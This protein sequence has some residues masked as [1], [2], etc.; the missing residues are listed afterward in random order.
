M[1]P[2]R[3]KWNHLHPVGQ[4]KPTFCHRSCN[5]AMNSFEKLRQE[6]WFRGVETDSPRREGRMTY[7]ERE[8]FSAAAAVK[9]RRWYAA[10]QLRKLASKSSKESSWE[11]IGNSRC[12]ISETR[13]RIRLTQNR[14][15]C[16]SVSRAR[17]N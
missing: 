16:A 10:Q 12:L 4:R 14:L 11:L 5:Q 1:D 6:E 2:N 7:Q 3:E 8:R 15:L 9:G 13:R 17:V